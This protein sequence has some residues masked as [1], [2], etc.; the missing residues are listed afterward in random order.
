[1]CIS[2]CVI[3]FLHCMCSYI[4]VC[5]VFVRG[6]IHTLFHLLQLKIQLLYSIMARVRVCGL[7]SLQRYLS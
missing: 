3:T 7:I 5:R 4:S 6:I 2:E 1:M